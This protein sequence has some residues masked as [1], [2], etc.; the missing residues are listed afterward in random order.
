VLWIFQ[1]CMTEIVI[2]RVH[3]G[4]LKDYDEIE[5]VVLKAGVNTVGFGSEVMVYDVSHV[6]LE[7]EVHFYF[8]D[9][10]VS[11]GTARVSLGFKPIIDSLPGFYRMYGSPYIDA[12]IEIQSR[13][14][15]RRL[16]RA[17]D[18]ND[19]GAEELEGEIRKVIL[20]NDSITNFV[21]LS[22]VTLVDFKLD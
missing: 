13:R 19:F 20:G 22:K 21:D 14:T 17:H 12:V 1:A 18:P 9:A 2:P 5:P 3:V 7:T 6:S 4:V 10:D 16:F 8:N 11:T 15:I